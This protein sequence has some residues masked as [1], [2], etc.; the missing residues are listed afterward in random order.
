MVYSP[1]YDLNLGEHIFPGAKY[2]LIHDR[3]IAEG[4]AKEEDF[5]EPPPVARED[6]LLVHDEAWI[7]KLE[8][9]RLSLMEAMRL[10]VPVSEQMLAAMWRMAGGT[11]LA[12]ENAFQ[13]GV[14]VNIGGG[15]HHAFRVHGKGF[16]PNHDVAPAVRHLH[17]GGPNRPGP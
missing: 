10:E 3:L 17:T 8:T 1:H 16:C 15:F 4:F 5:V 7:A 2:T 12:A 14:G 11:R 13:D 9:G 6:L